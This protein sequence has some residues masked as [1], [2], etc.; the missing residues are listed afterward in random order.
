[1]ATPPTPEADDERV[2][3]RRDLERLRIQLAFASAQISEAQQQR[4]RALANLEKVTTCLVECQTQLQ[5]AIERDDAQLVE[6]N[7]LRSL[8]DAHQEEVQVVT[9]ARR[10]V[11]GLY[12]ELRE[13]NARLRSEIV[14]LT[15]EPQPEPQVVRPMALVN[16][17]R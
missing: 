9:E 10:Q 4:D 14:S 12:E 3:T 11:Q 6:L 8:V 13:E 5:A 2:A 15:P 7:E 16:V 17:A 1:M